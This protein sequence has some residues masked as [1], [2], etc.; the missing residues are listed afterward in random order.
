[1]TAA[2]A[3]RARAVVTGCA[4]FG[5]RILRHVERDLDDIARRGF[6]GVLH[7]FSE[8]DLAY[9]RDTMG[10]IVEASHARGLEVQMNPWGLGRTFGGEA[11]S[12]FVTMQP[13]ACQVL[14]DG[15]RVAAGCLNAPAYRAYCREWAD[16]ALEA[17]TDLVFWDE[18][19]WVVPEHVG[20][21]DP[22]RWGCRC[23]V[24]RRLFRE[25]HG[26]ELPSALTRGVLAFREAS[27]R[28]FLR[29]L[30]AHVR[31]R[32]GRSTICLLPAVEGPHG[33]ADWD[34][35]AS[36]PGLDVFATDPYWKAFDA[37]AAPF[38]ERF[39]GLAEATARRHHVEP[40][41]WLPAFR[42]TRD[43]LPDFHRA[44][45]AA[46]TAGIGRIWVWAYDA[47]GHMS[48]L[49]TP[50]SAEVWEAVASAVAGAGT[51]PEPRRAQLA[52]LDLRSTRELVGLMNRE[53]AGVPEA[54]AAAADEIAAAIDAVVERLARG[55][56]L[57]YAG[58]G[59]SGLLASL[60]A[61][62]CEAT[63]SL[64]PGTVLALVAGGTTAPPLEQAAAED[65][66]AAGERELRAL[67]PTE[68]D[69]VVGVSAS[70]TT[71]Y[72]LGAIGAAR[73][74]GAL[75]IALVSAPGS[76][77]AQGADRELRVVVGP[78]VL[79]GSTRLKAGTAQK[80]VLN[81]IS[82]IAMIRLGKTFG[83]LMVDVAPVNEKLRA[84]VRRIVREASG[85]APERA[86]DALAAAH[87]DAKVAIVSLLAGVDVDAARARLDRA[88]GNVRSALEVG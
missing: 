38:V 17:G 42:L 8:N 12:R 73:E 37:E 81:M 85:A 57:I 84:R 58:A 15:R 77:L 88:D 49:A 56:R 67:D 36:L 41:L 9:Y 32:G 26:A 44:L 70:G 31:A 16:A 28:D 19:H 40:E 50:D 14:D 66:G 71:P 51:E 6:T 10:R 47:C 78:E 29:E 60:D 3:D 34:A 64:A 83:D 35:I 39:A 27:V 23:D 48:H 72:V 45:A 63:F 11:E 80:L 59:S 86:D 55:G 1:M 18:P 54:V 5:V 33:I 68:A 7:T 52:D 2:S 43:D 4:Y 62:E 20:I 30:V 22:D 65:D 82:T 79:A 76:K 69:V 46:R 21:D 75:T 53:D 74:Y 87:G 25:R 24:C 13:D 61:A